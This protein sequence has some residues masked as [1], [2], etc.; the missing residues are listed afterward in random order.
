[1]QPLNQSLQNFGRIG[2]PPDP[3]AQV[4][5]QDPGDQSFATWDA[6]CRSEYSNPTV[7]TIA[8]Y[9]VPATAITAFLP[10]EILQVE[11]QFPP[12]EIPR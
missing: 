8:K 11:D 6:V 2:C 5:V 1:L 4:L 7:N 9:F 12:S 10:K 3:I